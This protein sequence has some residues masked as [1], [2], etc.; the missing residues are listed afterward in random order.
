MEAND[1][2][3]HGRPAVAE[4]RQGDG[5]VGGD[6][7]SQ[8]QRRAGQPGHGVGPPRRECRVLDDPGTVGVGQYDTTFRRHQEQPG[9]TGGARR[10]QLD[11]VHRRIRE[12]AVDDVDLVEPAKRPQPQSAPAHDEIGRLGEVETEQAGQRGVLDVGRVSDAAGQQHDAR[13]GHRRQRGEVMT[14]LGRETADWSEVA[15]ALRPEQLG[16]DARHCGAVDDRVPDPCRCVGEVLHDPPRPVGRR[17]Q[18]DGVRRQPPRWR[19]RADRRQA[20]AGRRGQG[21]GRHPALSN[22]PARPVQVGEQCLHRLDA[23]GDTGGEL[24]ERGAVEDHRHRIEPPRSVPYGRPAVGARQVVDEMSG[25]RGGDQPVGLDL[26]TGQRGVVVQELCQQL[27]G[28][29]HRLPA[30]TNRPVGSGP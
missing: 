13:A 3:A 23:L 22:G 10:A 6:E 28:R 27:L 15:G 17:D 2:S 24:G 12:A 29:G 4:H 20:V 19:R 18:I 1:D 16:G 26:A 21:L 7:R 14:D 30:V 25:E 9:H 8:P 11:R 5:V